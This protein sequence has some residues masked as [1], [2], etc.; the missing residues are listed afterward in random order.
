M[1]RKKKI[2]ERIYPEIMTINELRSFLRVSYET[3]MGLIDA[4]K[5]PARRIG[6]DWKVPKCGVLDYLMGGD[7]NAP[8]A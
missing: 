1:P 6:R 2:E 4:G 8:T 5:I 3:A 7:P